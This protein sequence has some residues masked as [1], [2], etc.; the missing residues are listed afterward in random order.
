MDSLP[1]GIPLSEIPAGKPP[2]GVKP[3]LVDPNSLAHAIISVNAVFLALMLIFITLRIYTKSM[4]LHALW[5]D[6]CKS[7]MLN[8]YN[9]I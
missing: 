3:N 7:P 4:L 8:V 1:P 9:K 5:W 2:A 6:D